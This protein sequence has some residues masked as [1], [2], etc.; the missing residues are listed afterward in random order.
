MTLDD[1]VL[2]GQCGDWTRGCHRELLRPTRGTARKLDRTGGTS[3]SS[4]VGVVRNT[5]RR[6][7]RGRGLHALDRF[8]LRQSLTLRRPNVQG[9]SGGHTVE[10]KR[11]TLPDVNSVSSRVRR[12]WRLRCI[13]DRRITTEPAQWYRP[14]YLKPTSSGTILPNNTEPAGCSPVPLVLPGPFSIVAW[15]EC[16]LPVTCRAEG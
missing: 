16:G 1:H 6:E 4:L 15:R 2:P 7:D 14:V 11:R 8:E 3:P 12:G 5:R 13:F 10:T 9:E